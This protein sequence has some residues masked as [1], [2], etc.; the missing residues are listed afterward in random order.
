MTTDDAK[1]ASGATQSMSLAEAAQ[2]R[3][4]DAATVRF[5][6]AGSRLDMVVAGEKTYEKVSVRRAFPLSLPTDHFSVRDADNKEIGL[7]SG[8]GDLSA[9][10]HRLLDLELARRYLVAVIRKIVRVTE[11]FGTVDWD[12]ETD[13]GPCRF[14]TRDLREHAIRTGASH[15]LLS[16]V[17]KNRYEVPDLNALDPASQALLIRYL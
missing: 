13:R 17:E 7:L 4:I 12:V 3:V 8:I 6:K 15:Y 10:S 16:D 5:S 2:L 1:A 14:T 11:R 9:E